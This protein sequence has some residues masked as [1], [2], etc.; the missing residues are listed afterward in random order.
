MTAP[1][2]V[3]GGAPQELVSGGHLAGGVGSSPRRPDGTLKVTGQFA[4]GSDLWMEDMIWGVT[5]RSPMMCCYGQMPKINEWVVVKMNG[6]GVKPLH[7][8]AGCRCYN[9]IEWLVR[10]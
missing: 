3:P 6:A 7:C 9:R 8:S 4:Y 5:L 1:S 10:R 2:R